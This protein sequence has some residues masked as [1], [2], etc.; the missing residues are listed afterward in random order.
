MNQQV[1]KTAN[2]KERILI[3]GP[4]WIGD[5]VM[6]QSLFMGLQR[7]FESPQI[8]VLAP[9][10]SRPLLDR[11]PE[12]QDSLSLDLQHGELQLGKRREIGRGLIQRKFTRAIILPNSFKSA[13]IPM[14]AKIPIRTAWKGEW[15]N[16]LLSDCRKLDKDK[17]PLMVTRFTALG[18]PE[19]SSATQE[20]ENPRLQ[21]Q[22]EDVDQALTKFNLSTDTKVLAICPGAEFGP[23]KQWP[24]KQYAE[25]SNTLIA[26]GWQVWIFGSLSDKKIAGEIESLIEDKNGLAC[27][28]LTS[29]TNLAEAIDLMSV[30]S[31]VLS[32]DSGL[33]HIG[34]A[35]DKPVVAIYGSTTAD[36]TPPLSNKA[37]LLS[38]EISCRPCFKR[39]C[40]L[41]HLRCLT[42]VSAGSA[43]QALG[44]L[45]SC[46]S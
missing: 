4:S 12:V 36:F 45:A 35:L 26:K 33:M 25:V 16:I 29:K 27:K 23:S 38:T 30:T 37:K 18:L 2:S 24:A 7:R 9:Q 40:P 5:M 17:Y 28:N 15:R 42:E 19:Q 44:D 3:I 41:G 20:F 34:A 8:T 46:E 6:A 22:T 39:E 13:L 21:T 14:H 11:M 31:A 10:W 43:I 1:S 32:N